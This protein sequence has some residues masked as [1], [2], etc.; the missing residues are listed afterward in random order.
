MSPLGPRGL[1]N[2]VWDYFCELPGRGVGA[3]ADPPRPSWIPMV[4]GSGLI[5]SGGRGLGAICSF[6]R[7]RGEPSERLENHH[8]AQGP[9]QPRHVPDPPSI[10]LAQRLIAVSGSCQPSESVRLRFSGGLL[11]QVLVEL[12]RINSELQSP[13][14][15]EDRCGDEPEQES[16]DRDP[17]KRLKTLG[18]N[19]RGAE[20]RGY[21]SMRSEQRAGP[22]PDTRN[23][24][25]LVPERR[26]PGLIS[27]LLQRRH[28]PTV[29]AWADGLDLALV[30]RGRGRNR[31]L[32]IPPRTPTSPRAIPS[33]K[34]G[35]G[36]PLTVAFDLSA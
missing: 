15:E 36:W 24:R 4:V 28:R 12:T 2:A 32:T 14:S 8:G 29:R 33:A 16:P 10:L 22:L 9:G 17:T 18:S 11:V 19:G 5:C 20:K 34:R 7:E 31:P 30:V 13:W 26:P 3:G 21:E 6:Y 27:D 25:F 35:E 1:S 23:D